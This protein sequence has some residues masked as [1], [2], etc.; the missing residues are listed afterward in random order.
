VRL[1]GLSQQK[2]PMISLEIEAACSIVPQLT[3][4]ARAPSL[5]G[6]QIIYKTFQKC[7]LMTPGFCAVSRS[8]NP[9]K[10][11]GNRMCY[12]VYILPKESRSIH[13]FGMILE[14]NSDYF[15]IHTNRMVSV[16]EA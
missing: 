2:N 5:H 3:T 6:N 7:P 14:I 8:I 10:H 12:E 13:V 1:E 4:L 15:S 16:V 11:S 9:S